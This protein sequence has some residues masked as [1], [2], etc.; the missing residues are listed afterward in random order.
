[1]PNLAEVQKYDTE[2]MLP[3]L[4]AFPEQCRNAMEIAEN[5]QFNRQK[6][7]LP[8]HILIAGMGGSAIGADLVKTVLTERCSLPILVHRNYTIPDFVTDR[9][10]LLAVSYSGNTEETL[11]TVETGYARGAAVIAITSDGKLKQFTDDHHLPCVTIPAGQQP[12][13]SLG[14]LF[15]PLLS[16]LARLGFAPR[17]DYKSDLNETIELSTQLAE[18]FKPE[19]ADSLPKQLARRMHDKLPIVYA[20]Q[21]LEAVAVR[22]KGQI[23]ENSKSL[24]YCNVYPEMNHNEIEGWRHP[25]NLTSQCHVIQLRD[26]AAHIQTN[27]RMDITAELIQEYTGG[28]THVYS[29]GRSFLARLFSLIFIGDWASFYLAIRYEQ[30]PTPVARIQEL[31]KRLKTN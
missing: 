23:N 25:P 17:L 18:R 24:A 14:Y 15:I 9:T 26:S 4:K 5:F 30:N 7:E 16:I 20:P 1:M 10:L 2:D 13:A 12:R 29:Q 21:E 3:L 8:N 6:Q 31:K 22:W 27:R 11:Q 19:V 28:I